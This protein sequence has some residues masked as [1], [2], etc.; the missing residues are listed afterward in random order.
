M[1]AELR[2]ELAARKAEILD[3]LR[4]SRILNGDDGPL[5]HPVPRGQPLPLSFAQQR[6]WMIEQMNP[7]GSGYHVGLRLRLEGALSV[8]ALRW[9]IVELV[10]RHESLRTRFPMG[11]DGP[12]QEIVTDWEPSLE[13]IDF[14][15]KG[16]WE[17]AE[18]EA[19]LDAAREGQRAYDLAAGPLVRWRLYRLDGMRHLFWVGMHH[20]V[21]DGWS[22]TVMCRELAEFYEAAVTQRPAHLSPLSLQYADFAVWQRNWLSGDVLQKQLDYW[23]GQLA[24]ASRLEVPADRPPLPEPA[25]SWSWRAHFHKP[26]G[27]F[28]A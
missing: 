7:G 6:L 3:F 28:R 8:S 10:R 27:R 14:S 22:L 20:I 15:Q 24:G 21:T 11:D 19:L 25:F 17:R 18:A 5:L 12:V 16:S 13:E 1:T 2:E 23:R 26:G 4:E 9:A